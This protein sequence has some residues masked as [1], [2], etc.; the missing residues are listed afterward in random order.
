MPQIIKSP[1]VKVITENGS[2][3]LSITVEPIVIE[4]TINV[5]SDGKL[6]ISSSE[7]TNIPSLIKE[8]EEPIG[9]AIPDFGSSQ[10]IKFGKTE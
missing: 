2:T 6:N 1:K 4:I 10:Q 7:K 3:D 9:W 8:E 5:N